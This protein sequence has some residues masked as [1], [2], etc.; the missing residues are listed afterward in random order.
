MAAGLPTVAARSGGLAE[1]VPEEGQ[2]AAG[3]VHALAQRLTALY[4]DAQAGERAL[5]LA[6]ERYAPP[7][8]AATLRE[9][10]DRN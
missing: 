10:Y 7:V 8:I 9:V 4:R 1:A 2:Y 5:A 6:R 3:D